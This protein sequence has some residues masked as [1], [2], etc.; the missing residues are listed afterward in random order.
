LRSKTLTGFNLLW[1][2]VFDAQPQLSVINN[3]DPK[4]KN[5]TPPRITTVSNGVYC[6]ANDMFGD[7]FVKVCLLCALLRAIKMELIF[8]Y[9]VCAEWVCGGQCEPH[10]E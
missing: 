4:D 9:V 10:F 1:G 6:L 8:M 5:G 7:E 2:N 3:V